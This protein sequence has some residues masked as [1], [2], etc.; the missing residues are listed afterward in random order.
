MKIGAGD[1]A[2][3]N[4]CA[5]P[6]ETE[7]L[8]DC[9]HKGNGACLL[10]ANQECHL[11]RNERSPEIGTLSAAIIGN[12]EPVAGQS[13]GP[14]LLKPKKT[15]WHHSGRYGAAKCPPLSAPLGDQG[16]FFLQIV[17]YSTLCNNHGQQIVTPVW[18]FFSLIINLI[19]KMPCSPFLLTW[20][21]TSRS[22]FSRK[23]PEH[24][25]RWITA[26]VLMK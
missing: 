13:F 15:P 9:G 8:L 6:G 5:E 21:F 11:A 4:F 26:A 19:L 7:F 20:I 3:S 22:S 14:L 18:Y 25:A 24:I 12:Y 16:G 17:L 1:F 23:A 10:Q 2:D